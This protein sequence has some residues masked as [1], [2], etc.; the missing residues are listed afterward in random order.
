MTGKEYSEKVVSLAGVSP[1][2]PE[3]FIAALEKV[4]AETGLSFIIAICLNFLSV[5]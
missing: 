2:K 3:E 1:D 4:K 5:K